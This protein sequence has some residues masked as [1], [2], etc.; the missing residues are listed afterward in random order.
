M[1]WE[2]EMPICH[3]DH[4]MTTPTML[5][6]SA[7]IIHTTLYCLDW[8]FANCNHEMQPHAQ[9]RQTIQIVG[10]RGSHRHSLKNR[11]GDRTD[12]ASCSGFY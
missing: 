1:E 12:K 4:A 11:T 7:S 3:R 8:K 9:R 6:F 10:P 2:K 5:F